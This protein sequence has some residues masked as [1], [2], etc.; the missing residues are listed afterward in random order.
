[1]ICAQ[2]LTESGSG[3]NDNSNIRYYC[4]TEEL[5]DVVET[6]NGIIGHKRTR[7]KRHCF[8]CD[9]QKHFFISSFLN[10]CFFLSV[11]EAVLKKK[12]CNITRQVIDL[13][14]ALCVQ[15]AE[16]FNLD[17]EEST[18]NNSKVIVDHEQEFEGEED[19]NKDGMLIREQAQGIED[20]TLWRYCRV[21]LE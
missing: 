13:Y 10:F 5:F 3:E 20:N 4:K 8:V 12:Y 7:G 2:N 19:A 6:A 14:L 11:M 1:M 18:R 17:E 16:R 15:C 9:S 21:V